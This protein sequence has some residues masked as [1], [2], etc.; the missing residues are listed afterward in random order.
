[1][2]G[3]RLW[4]LVGALLVFQAFIVCSEYKTGESFGGKSSNERWTLGLPW[5]P[6]YERTW[7]S[8]EWEGLGNSCLRFV[9]LSSG[10]FWVGVVMLWGAWF[11]W[12]FAAEMEAEKRAKMVQHTTPTRR[13]LKF[14]SLDDIVCDAENLLAKGYDKAG[15]WDFAQVCNHCTLWVKYPLDGFPKLPLWLKPIFLVVKRTVLPK[16]ERQMRETKTMPAGMST[17]P[18]TV[19]PPGQDEAAALAG[20]KLQLERYKTHA[21]PMHPSPLRGLLSLAEWE[22]TAKTHC[23]HHLSFLVP[24]AG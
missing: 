20:L 23:A 3:R 7:S 24:K 12:D 16:L 4:I 19:F 8:N 1:M 6:W 14:D 17:A 2:I 10:M 15:Q 5:S 22:D 13:Q 9:S 18:M 21:G 11:T